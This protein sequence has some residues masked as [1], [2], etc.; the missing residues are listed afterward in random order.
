MKFCAS[1]A[2]IP[3]GNYQFNGDLNIDGQDANSNLPVSITFS[4]NAPIQI[5]IPDIV[6]VYE[7]VGGSSPVAA[8]DPDGTAVAATITPAGLWLALNSR[9]LFLPLLWV[10]L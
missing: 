9:M 3:P 7:G 2:I 5:T 10:D 6:H 1:P 8:M 4:V